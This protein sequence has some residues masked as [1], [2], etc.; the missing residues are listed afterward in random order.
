MDHILSIVL[1]TPLAGFLV[2]LF[3]P[4]S[5]P[6]AIKL[7]ANIASF[8]SFLVCLPL[9]FGFDRGKDFQFVEKAT[10][11]RRSAPAT[12]WASTGTACCW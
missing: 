5:K 1:L 7:W 11:Y 10:G 6:A 12:I 8:A 2:L 4:S 9:I 3:I